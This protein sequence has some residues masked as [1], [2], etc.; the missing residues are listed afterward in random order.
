MTYYDLIQWLCLFLDQR[1][2]ALIFLVS[3]HPSFFWEAGGSISSLGGEVKESGGY[4]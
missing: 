4:K 2:L 3:S 1:E